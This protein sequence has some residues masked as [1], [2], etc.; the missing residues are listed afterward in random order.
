M[1]TEYGMWGSSTSGDDS[2]ACAC[3][4]RPYVEGDPTPMPTTACRPGEFHEKG[5]CSP[6]LPGTFTDA[7]GEQECTVCGV[8]EVAPNAGS[9]QCEV[10]A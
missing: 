9:T 1:T 2:A 8:G 3:E 6:C 4:Y 10:R 7:Y 5:A